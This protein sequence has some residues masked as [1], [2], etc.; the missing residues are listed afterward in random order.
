METSGTVEEKSRA[1]KERAMNR[2][3]S[4]QDLAGVLSSLQGQ[5]GEVLVKGDAVGIALLAP[6]GVL[7]GLAFQV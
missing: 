5:A 6:Q 4:R 1:G 3:L 2:R 7:A